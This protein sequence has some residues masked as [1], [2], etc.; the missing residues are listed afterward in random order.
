MGPGLLLAD[1]YWVRLKEATMPDEVSDLTAQE[2]ID[3][4][5]RMQSEA[6]LE[7]A[8]ADDRVTVARAAQDR[9]AEIRGEDEDVPKTY[10][11]SDPEQ[12]D[13]PQPAFADSVETET[14]N[15][16]IA[17]AYWDYQYTGP[18]P[19]D[20]RNVSIGVTNAEKDEEESN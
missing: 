17:K 13:E 19:D 3:K 5:S 18:G 15:L 8:A 11:V 10:E 9:L 14:P 1:T 7:D 20:A 12:L 6:K 16:R 4:I 2:A